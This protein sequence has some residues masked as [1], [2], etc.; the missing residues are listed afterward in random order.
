[1]PWPWRGQAPRARPSNDRSRFL[2]QEHDVLVRIVEPGVDPLL[3]EPQARA[4]LQIQLGEVRFPEQLLMPPV[5][6]LL[7]FWRIV[8]EPPDEAPG[9]TMDFPE[10][11]ANVAGREMNQH[12]RRKDE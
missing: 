11:S 12:A 2:E 5:L 8:L 4:R 10:S 1:L 7:V 6:H 3:H 9:A